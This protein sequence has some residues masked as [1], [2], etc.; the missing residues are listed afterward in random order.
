VQRA[1]KWMPHP[2]V[3][4]LMV[5]LNA[6]GLVLWAVMFGDRLA[7]AANMHSVDWC[8]VLLTGLTALLWVSSHGCG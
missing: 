7:R 1:Y 8:D 4:A 3:Y 2:I 5:G 6:V